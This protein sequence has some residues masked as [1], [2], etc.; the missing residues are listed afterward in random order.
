MYKYLLITLLVLTGCSWWGQTRPDEPWKWCF[1]F[2]YRK[3]EQI[4]YCGY[5]KRDCERFR[6]RMKSAPPHYYFKVN[7]ACYFNEDKK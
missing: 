4:P 3:K 5:N 7:S 6:E 1:A 2:D